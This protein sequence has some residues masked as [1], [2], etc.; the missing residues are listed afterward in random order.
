MKSNY[1]LGLDEDILAMADDMP[2][3]V[4]PNPLSNSAGNA[5]P[6]ST[7]ALTVD[8]P[9]EHLTLLQSYSSFGTVVS[10]LKHVLKFVNV[11]K[12]RL[13]EKST[14]FSHF[15]VLSESELVKTAYRKVILRDQEIHFP[16][17]F[18]YLNSKPLMSIC[19]I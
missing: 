6:H 12:H 7:A 16:D 10:V 2:S 18:A 4:V 15:D 8:V 9:K 14:K 1:F 19:R 5:S 17:I 3:T 11:L 13:K